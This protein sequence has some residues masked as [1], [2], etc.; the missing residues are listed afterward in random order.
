MSLPVELS[1]A[2][3]GC[4][5]Q[6]TDDYSTVGKMTLRNYLQMVEEFVHR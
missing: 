3:N 5:F 6:L 2:D 1:D 4:D